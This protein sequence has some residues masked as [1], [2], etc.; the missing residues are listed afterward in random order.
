MN[1]EERLKVAKIQL[2]YVDFGKS[3]V[4]GV[5]AKDKNGRNIRLN[6]RPKTNWAKEAELAR[7]K[8]NIE[9]EEEITRARIKYSS[10]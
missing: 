7:S 8:A 5:K 9:K 3:Y 10:T 4:D 2:L 1:W 6:A